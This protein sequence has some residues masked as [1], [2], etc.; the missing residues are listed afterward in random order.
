MGA[1]C[2]ELCIH[3]RYSAGSILDIS[4]YRDTC[5]RSI[6]I[7]YRDTSIHRVSNDAYDT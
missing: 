2:V 6:P 1:C 7:R 5:E 3:A 4:K